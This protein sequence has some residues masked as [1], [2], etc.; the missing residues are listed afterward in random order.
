MMPHTDDTYE[1]KYTWYSLCVFLRRF[2][3]VALA[4]QRK[5]EERE[6]RR[7]AA[8]GLVPPGVTTSGAKH[9]VH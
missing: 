7:Q 1:P 6:Y 4:I 9:A 3:R 8:L 5:Q 2:E